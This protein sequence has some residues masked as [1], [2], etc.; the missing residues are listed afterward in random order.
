MTAAELRAAERAVR[1]AVERAD[2]ARDARDA[3]V[4]QALTEGWTMNAI[5][6][7]LGIAPQRVSQ[8]ARARGSRVWV[9]S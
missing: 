6:E 9:A 5:A 8:I 3:L 2:R 4:I 7:A 1:A